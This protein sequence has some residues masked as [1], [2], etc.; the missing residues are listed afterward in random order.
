MGVLRV[1]RDV[2]LEQ[3]WFL[4]TLSLMNAARPEGLALKR[5]GYAYEPG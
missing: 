3:R 4:L 5:P 1:S 2:V